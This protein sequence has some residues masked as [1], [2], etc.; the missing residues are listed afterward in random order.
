MDL[1]TQ[2]VGLPVVNLGTQI[3]FNFPFELSF[4]PVD[5]RIEIETI[6]F[7]VHPFDVEVSRMQIWRLLLDHA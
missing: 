5:F 1:R 7:R 4:V 6:F 2:L 3:T